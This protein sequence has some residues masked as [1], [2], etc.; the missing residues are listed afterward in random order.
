MTCMKGQSLFESNKKHLIELL[1]KR[2]LLI[3]K[4][5]TCVYMCYYGFAKYCV[6]KLKQQKSTNCIHL[7]I[8]EKTIYKIK[9]HKK[10]DR[11][12]V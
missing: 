4:G 11:C 7:L 12:L 8:Q 1:H 2:C 6:A 10:F 5:F 9:K 3:V